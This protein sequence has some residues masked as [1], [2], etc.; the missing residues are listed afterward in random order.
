M[1]SM[2]DIR[3]PAEDPA[4]TMPGTTPSPATPIARPVARVAPAAASDPRTAQPATAPVAATAFSKPTL[5]SGT[6]KSGEPVY[7]NASVARM[8]ARAG[9]TTQNF[10]ARPQ[11]GDQVQK[12]ATPAVQ[13]SAAQAPAA[14]T[15]GGYGAST[16]YGTSIS[17][18]TP[19]ASTFGQ[20]VMAIPD[21][22]QATIQRP[23]GRLR[24]P[25]AMAEHH[26]S[27]DSK[28]ASKRLLD[29]LDTQRFRLEMIA[30][31][32][33]RRGR[34][35]IDA[36]DDNARQ[37][38]A[39][40][41]GQQQQAGDAI[42]GR[43][44]RAARLAGIDAEQAGQD[45]RTVFTLDANTATADADRAQAREIAG[46][47]DATRRAGIAA[48]ST[49]RSEYRMLADGTLLTVSGG[50]ATRV[51]GEDGQPVRLATPDANA[52]SGQDL[53]KAYTDQR[54]AI[55][56]L[57][58]SLSP[59][60]LGAHFEALDQSPL[61]VRY[62]ETLNG[63]AQGGGGGGQNPAKPSFEVFRARAA[64]QGSRM[65]PEQLRAA[66]DDL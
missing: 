66:Y 51:T 42:Q 45:R 10:G 52:L 55:L 17:R 54:N 39:I 7:D 40:I 28:E 12:P 18:P 49:P 29:N 57:A 22:N 47:E 60:D 31:N 36:L 30:N 3:R 4:K 63:N 48:S 13:P 9:V 26:A 34:A 50:K 58:E 6:G 65:S 32:P 8:G 61:G 16:G 27:Q 23:T 11:A 25:D 37:Q 43:A 2:H 38:A 59:E 64:A 19:A 33:G 5:N 35:A 56:R 14:A 41:G 62:A 24:G 1:A 44:D 46:M 20:S 53:V 15:G 21:D